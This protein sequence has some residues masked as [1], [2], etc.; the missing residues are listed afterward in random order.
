MHH[1]RYTL[2]VWYNNCNPVRIS[3]IH[4]YDNTMP[5]AYIHKLATTTPGTW[6]CDNHCLLLGN[7]KHYMP[8]G[9]KSHSGAS[10]WVVKALDPRSN[11]GVR[12]PRRRSEEKALGKTWIHI[13][14]G[15]TAVNGY[16]VHRSKVGSTVAAAFR[17]ILARGGIV[18]SDEYCIET[19][20]LNKYLYL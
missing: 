12:F 9:R 5:F 16:L 20:P 15:H 4:L 19:W 7:M 14:S 3:M 8:S 17:A 13:A 6:Y 2:L 18:K 10:G 1:I 11:S